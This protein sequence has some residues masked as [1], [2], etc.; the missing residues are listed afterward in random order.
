MVSSSLG[1]TWRPTFHIPLFAPAP[2]KVPYYFFELSRYLGLCK[3]LPVLRSWEKGDM[4]LGEMAKQAQATG[5]IIAL[6]TG[7]I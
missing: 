3:C 6:Q 1:S 4:E 5:L 2:R 7:A